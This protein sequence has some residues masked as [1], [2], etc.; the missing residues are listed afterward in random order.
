MAILIESKWYVGGQSSMVRETDGSTAEEADRLYDLLVKPLEGTH[1]GEY[2]AVSRGGELLLASSLLE[3]VEQARSA[4]GP[5]SYVFQ[6]G[7]KVVGSWR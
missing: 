3:A 5:D 4:Y 2:A 7:Q 6:V 1:H